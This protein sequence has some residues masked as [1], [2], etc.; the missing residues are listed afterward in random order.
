MFIIVGKIKKTS[1]M[2]V[3]V[4]ELLHIRKFVLFSLNATPYTMLEF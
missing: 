3:R 2:L 1:R 4:L